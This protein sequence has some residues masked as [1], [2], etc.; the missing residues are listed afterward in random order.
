MGQGPLNVHEGVTHLVSYVL[1]F[2]QAILSVFVSLSAC[3]SDEFMVKE[4]VGD[5]F[6]SSAC[7]EPFDPAQP[8]FR[9]PP[10]EHL[11]SAAI[12]QCMRQGQMLY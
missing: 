3:V 1:H 6:W 10:P 9:H 8:C 2:C 7:L 5:F 4:A 11:N 12:T